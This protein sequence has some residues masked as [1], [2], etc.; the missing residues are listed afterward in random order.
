MDT[1]LI[2]EDDV[3]LAEELQEILEEEGYKVYCAHTA[4]QGMELLQKERV[5]LCLIDIRLP[6]GSGYDLCQAARY[7]YRGQIIMLTVCDQEE[8][9]VRGFK[10]GADDYVVKPFKVKELLARIEVR[11]KNMGITSP[12]KDNNVIRTGDLFIDRNTYQVWK[13]GKLIPLSKTDFRLVEK[14][15]SNYKRVMTREQ[16]ID[17]LWADRLETVEDGALST[18]LCRVREKLGDYHGESYIKTVRG[19]GLSWSIP[20]MDS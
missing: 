16:M 14:L 11:I 13:N 12:D 18:Q 10:S 4:K 17:H 6:D 19:V 8:E 2:I 20:V 3:D 9:I 5:T 1:I 15:A 7:F